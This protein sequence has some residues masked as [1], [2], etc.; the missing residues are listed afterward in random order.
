MQG[1]RHVAP[2]MFRSIETANHRNVCEMSSLC[3]FAFNRMF[4]CVVWSKVSKSDKRCFM[5]CVVILMRNILLMLT[6]WIRND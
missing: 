3:H 4:A 6:M 2:L 5:Q 1:Y